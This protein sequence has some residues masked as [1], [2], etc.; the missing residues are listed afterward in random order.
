MSPG[1]DPAPIVL[2]IEDL[3]LR[4]GRRPALE[5]ISLR[6]R[7]GDR[8]AVVGPNGAG[9]S[10]LFKAITGMFEPSAGRIR[11]HGHGPGQDHCVAYVPQRSDVDWGFPLSVADVVMQGRAAKVGLLRRP[12][13][14]DHRRVAE[15]LAVL[16]LEHLADRPI[17]ALSGGQQ[18]R[19]FIARALAQDAELVLMDEPFS[20]LD[21][22]SR[23]DVLGA[24]NDLDERGVA[25]MLATHD[26]RLATERFEQILLLD[27]RLVAYGPPET[28]ITDE[29]LHQ[30]FGGRLHAIET[31]GGKLIFGDADCEIHGHPRE[32][33]R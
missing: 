20:G 31:A 3:S 33:I 10:S 23:E 9:K 32:P 4:Y 1:R 11:V 7:A 13:A 12:G 21:A 22:P 2:E 5:S 29:H 26:L 6:V 15:S 18:Q 30:A 14:E 24:L 25:V 17:A 8:V 27:R 16:R 28:V 19:M